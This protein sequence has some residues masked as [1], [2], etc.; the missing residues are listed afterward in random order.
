MSLSF[1][2]QTRG[3]QGNPKDNFLPCFSR[4]GV[5]E[6]LGLLLLGTP[7][8]LNKESIINYPWSLTW[9]PEGQFKER[10]WKSWALGQSES[11]PR[12]CLLSFNSFNW[13]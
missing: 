6:T 4:D 9:A 5:G 10:K 2:E 3:A 1:G 8:F 11:K 12:S 13:N 7:A